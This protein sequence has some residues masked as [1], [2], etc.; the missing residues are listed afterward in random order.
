MQ[1]KFFEYDRRGGRVGANYGVYDAPVETTDPTALLD[2][3]LNV[4]RVGG[5]AMVDIL[6]PSQ[7]MQLEGG[8]YC[9]TW[10]TLYARQSSYHW[11][12]DTAFASDC[13]EFIR[14]C[15]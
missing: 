10:R 7:R 8:G 14:E 3:I 13:E 9:E 15:K 4:M 2:R 1:I 5:E 11:H 6:L 12:G